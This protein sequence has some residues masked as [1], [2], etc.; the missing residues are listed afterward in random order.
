MQTSTPSILRRDVVSD[1]FA[2]DTFRTRFGGILFIVVALDQ[3][4]DRDAFIFESEDPLAAFGRAVKLDRVAEGIDEW[5]FD[6]RAGCSNTRPR[7]FTV[8]NR[9]GRAVRVTIPE[10]A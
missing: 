1:R 6:R 8:F 5:H 3:D 2:V 10:R 7:R 4:P 9:D